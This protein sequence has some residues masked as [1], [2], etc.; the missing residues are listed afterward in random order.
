MCLLPSPL[1]ARCTS[2][3]RKRNQNPRASLIRS[4]QVEHPLPIRVKPGPRC[5]LLRVLLAQEREAGPQFLL[6]SIP[7]GQPRPDTGPV[8]PA[9]EGPTDRGS[10][11]RPGSLGAST[12]ASAP[13]PPRPPAR[14]DPEPTPRIPGSAEPPQPHHWVGMHVGRIAGPRTPK[15]RPRLESNRGS[16]GPG[17]DP[18]RR[19]QEKETEEG[20]QGKREGARGVR[21]GSGGRAV[22]VGGAGLTYLSSAPPLPVT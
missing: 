12:E 6:G 15:W 1:K 11:E 21:A 16:A 4:I 13:L 18:R 20:A 22:G 5:P 17:P 10:Q 9:R 2:R 14:R 7:L 8:P 3:F 19:A